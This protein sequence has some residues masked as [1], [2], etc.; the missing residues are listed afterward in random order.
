MQTHSL[1]PLVTSQRYLRRAARQC[2]RR[3]SS[4]GI[5]GV[6]WRAYRR[7]FAGKISSLSE[8]LSIGKW[9]PSPVRM[10]TCRFITGKLLSIAI[11][12]VEDRVVHRAVRNAL[13]PVL[14]RDVIPEWVSG[15]LPGRSRITSVRQAAEHIYNGFR[16]VCNVD[17]ADVSGVRSSRDVSELVASWVSDGSLIA[18]IRRILDALPSP[19]AIGSGLS[20]TLIHLRLAPI[21]A[22]LSNLGWRVVRFADTY[23]VFCESPTAARIAHRV[24]TDILSQN[25]MA[26]ADAKSWVRE[27]VNPEDLFMVD[28]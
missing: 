19:M 22:A 5:D 8:S 6:T 9:R 14:E 27:H 25:G 21:D 11:P 15:Y 20:P 23:C 3:S 7:D 10:V 4:P 18:L 28:G 13:L 26:V 1:M 12:T 24:I 16:S 2:M 17:V